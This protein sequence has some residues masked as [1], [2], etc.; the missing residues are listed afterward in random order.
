MREDGGVLCGAVGGG[1]GR[2]G[3]GGGGGGGGG[4]AGEIMHTYRYNTGST[5]RYDD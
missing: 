1:G 3:G 2:M 5:Q 4:V